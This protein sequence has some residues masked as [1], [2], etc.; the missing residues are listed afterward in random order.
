MKIKKRIFSILFALILC[1]AMAIPVFAESDMPRLIDNAGLLTD[2]EQSELLA[3]LDEI[4][5]RQQVDIVVVTTDTLEG[6]TPRNYADDFYDY[7]GYGY[8]AEYDGI[9]L[10]VSME[11][12]DWWISTCGYG[13]TAITDDGIDYIS[14]KFL[15][16]LKDGNYAN[17][18][19]TYAG[20][21]DEFISQAK[22]GQPYDGNHMPKKPFNTVLWVVVAIGTGIGIAIGITGSMRK[23]LQP[24]KMQSAAESYIKANSMNITASRDMFLYRTVTRTE[25]PKSG[26]DSSSSSSGGS[27]T[28]RSSSGQ[29]HGGGGGKF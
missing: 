16:Y 26:S 13:I 1:M 5:E 28:H 4:S 2:A 14:D 21:C 20:L 7:N 24:V 29:T 18:F 23:E 8:G 3:M 9:L 12:R 17:A 19:S 15:P 22:T 6:K 25:R 10:L 27:S 11:D